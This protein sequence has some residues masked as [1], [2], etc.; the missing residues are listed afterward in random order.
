VRGDFQARFCE[1]L[2]V[3][4]PL[5]TRPLNVRL[6]KNPH[7]FVHTFFTEIPD[8]SSVSVSLAM[9]F[10]K[11]QD[12]SQTHLFPV[13][14]DQSIDDDNEVRLIDIFVDSL[15]PFRPAQT[16][17]LWL[18][19]QSSFIKGSGKRVQKKYRGDVAIEMPPARSQ[20]H[21]QFSQGQPQ[22]H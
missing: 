9:K 8:K 6:S 14:L 3:K 13:S 15:S 19:E 21:L 10:I 12:R 16:L 5:S 2:G 1:R 20:Y 4:L 11:G 17:H 22:S 7:H 18:F